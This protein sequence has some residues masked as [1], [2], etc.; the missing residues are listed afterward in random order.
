[1]CL[2][3]KCSTLQGLH[4]WPEGDSREQVDAF[5]NSTDSLILY[6][7]QPTDQARPLLRAWG[8]LRL[9]YRHATI[10]TL[11]IA[12]LFKYSQ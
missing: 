6:D 12:R 9:D 4:Y 2:R 7:K 10:L 3:Y 11:R 1:M 8:P 5:V